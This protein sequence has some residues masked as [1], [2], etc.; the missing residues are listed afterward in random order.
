MTSSLDRLAKRVS[1]VSLVVLVLGGTFVLGLVAESRDLPPVPQLRS[2]YQTL[3]NLGDDDA[4][5]HPRR[6]HLQPTRGQGAGVTVDDVD[7]DALVMMAGFFD[8]ENQVRLV[9]RDGTVVQRW[10]LDYFEHFPDPESRPCALEDPLRVDLHGAQVT[11]E[12][13]LVVNY[14]YCGTV[15]LDSCGQ[16]LWRIEDNTHHSLVTAESGGYWILGRDEFLAR[17]HPDRYPPLLTPGPAQRVQ[18]DTILR[19]GEDGEVRDEISIPGLMRENGLEAF[20]TADG[21]SFAW[22]DEDTW[23]LVHANKATELSPDVADAFPQFEAGD[24][25]ISLRALNLVMVVDPDTQQVRW[26]QTGPWLRQHDP[27]FHPDGRISVFNNNV[28]YHTAYDDRDQTILSTPFDTTIMSVD[29]ETG[30]TEVTFGQAPGEEMLSVVRGDH[31]L[32]DD[33]GIL[34]T[35]FDAGR[36]LQVDGDG[37]VVWEYVNQRDDDFVGEVTN[38]AVHRPEDLPDEWP[39]CDA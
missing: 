15:K 2:A 39:G 13:E 38:A 26:H 24:L 21:P 30:E 37:Q 14:E 28:Y 1:V 22:N 6:H 35:E 11:P 25:A 34:I 18:E 20:L 32:L 19:V 3:T 27:E 7:D 17:D 5:S 10:S 16:L 33:D 29:P 12:G 36:V 23:D 31:Q 9:E 8:D 4:T